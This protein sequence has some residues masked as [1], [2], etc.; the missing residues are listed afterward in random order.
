M[1]TVRAV[2]GAIQVEHD[3]PEALLADTAALVAEVLSRNRVR[4]SDEIISI[5]FTM[6]PD[7]RAGFPAA[8]VRRLGLADVPVMC[9]TELAVPD[10]LPR[11]V[12]LL[13][14]IHTDLAQSE[15]AHVYLRGAVALRPDLAAR[16]ADDERKRA[17]GHRDV[18]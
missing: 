12:R 14:H 18:A 5:L 4:G 7:L 1:T 16:A 9:A 10:A 6:T 13:A 8:A 3:E 2:R 11:V 15:V 17:H